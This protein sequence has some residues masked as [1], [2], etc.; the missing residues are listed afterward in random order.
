MPTSRDYWKPA[1]QKKKNILLLTYLK[2]LELCGSL[3]RQGQ[4]NF[5]RKEGERSNTRRG[6]SFG[7]LVRLLV[8]QPRSE[9]QNRTAGLPLQTALGQRG[10]SCDAPCKMK[11]FGL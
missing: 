5:D 10:C 2:C 9:Q 3:S 1:F 7:P 8:F 11:G 4:Q 6:A